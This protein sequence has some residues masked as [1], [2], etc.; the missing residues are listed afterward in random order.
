MVEHSSVQ[1][2]GVPTYKGT[3]SD[4]MMHVSPLLGH[5]L[6][7]GHVQE[8]ITSTK[9]MSV[10]YICTWSQMAHAGNG[11][12]IVFSLAHNYFNFLFRIWLLPL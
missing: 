5:V 4:L 1:P 2:D 6:S 9:G 10:P 12:L 3:W 8:H 11:V 7:T